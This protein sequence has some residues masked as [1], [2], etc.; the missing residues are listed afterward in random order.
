MRPVCAA[1]L[2]IPPPPG[3]DSVQIAAPGKRLAARPPHPDGA[4]LPP[5]RSA[6]VAQTAEGDLG[7]QER[8]VGQDGVVEVRAR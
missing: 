8:L 6:R 7:E 3:E 2:T 5:E 4:A 1:N